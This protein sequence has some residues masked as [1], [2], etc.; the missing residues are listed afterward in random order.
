MTVE[1]YC[2]MPISTLSDW[3]KNLVLGFQLE[4]FSNDC[5]K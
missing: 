2:A 3:V 4:Q 5:R 1:N